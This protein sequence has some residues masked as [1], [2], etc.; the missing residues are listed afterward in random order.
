MQ[1]DAGDRVHHGGESGN[2]QYIAPD[3]DGALF[4]GALDF[5]NAL[6]VRHRAD[7]PN[8]VEDGASVGEEQ[9]AEL[10]I[11]FPG[12]SDGVFVNLFALLIEKE[13]KLGDIGLCAIEPDVAL[14]LL[15]GIVKRMGVEKGPNELTADIF[16]AEF[17]MSVLVDGV[18]AAVKGRGADIHAL[19]IGNFFVADEPR[20]IA[21]ACSS[22]GRIKRMREG[23]AKSDARRRG[24]DEFTGGRAFKHAGLR[25]HDGKL[26][27]TDAGGGD[28]S[29]P[30]FRTVARK[31]FREPPRVIPLGGVGRA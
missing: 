20:R 4:R 1:N 29:A 19:L 24:F 7:V 6:G 17:E 11:V 23:V 15:L 18:V 12:A 22:D 25:G 21:G 28:T 3:F 9:D 16:E 8:V 30:V 2:R 27:Y 10:A 26:F 14:A 31:K 13:R 5:L